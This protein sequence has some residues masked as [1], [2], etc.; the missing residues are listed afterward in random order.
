VRTLAPFALSLVT[1]IAAAQAP[2]PAAKDEQPVAP[3]AAPARAP[4][5]LKLDNPSQYATQLPREK[6]AEGLPTLGSDA[7]PL[8]APDPD[9]PRNPYP[10]DTTP[11]RY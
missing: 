8:P 4:L 2:K 6:G 11:G 9:S 1:G 10:K 7:R 3:P 5:N